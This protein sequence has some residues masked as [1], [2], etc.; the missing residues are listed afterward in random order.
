MLIIGLSFL[1]RE[2]H[3][4]LLTLAFPYNGFSLLRPFLTDAY[5]FK[6]LF[7]PGPSFTRALI[8]VFPLLLS[9]IGLIIGC[10]NKHEREVGIY[11]DGKEERERTNKKMRRKSSLSAN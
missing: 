6:S 5:P 4:A 2:F 9:Y 7:L 10:V 11:E 8:K 3:V 1:L